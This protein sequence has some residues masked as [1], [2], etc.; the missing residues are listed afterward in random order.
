MSPSMD[1]KGSTA[2]LR[3]QALRFA[4][5]FLAAVMLL[6]CF[7]S[8]AGMRREKYHVICNKDIFYNVKPFYRAGDKVKIYFPFVATDTDYSFYLN[9]ERISTDSYSDLK[10]YTIT[11]T[12]PAEDVELTMESRNSM[13]NPLR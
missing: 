3:K 7:S 5:F 9:G 10:G 12:M 11:F 6:T 1:T 13:A 2:S 4:L 8:C